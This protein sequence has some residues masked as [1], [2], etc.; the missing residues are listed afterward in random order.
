MRDR[1]KIA[2]SAIQRYVDSIKRSHFT[3]KMTSI[4]HYRHKFISHCQPPHYQRNIE[5]PLA[6]RLAHTN[7]CLNG[8]MSVNDKALPT[9]FMATRLRS[10][11]KTGICQQ[12]IQILYG[13]LCKW[14]NMIIMRWLYDLYVD[15]FG[16]FG[17]ATRKV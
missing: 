4:A 8:I 14:I 6:A 2:W 13:A 9:T 17:P 3:Y 15:R 11:T 1:I 10:E 5:Y 16:N 7:T 12:R